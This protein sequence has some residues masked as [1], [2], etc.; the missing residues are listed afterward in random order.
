[1]L[2][3]CILHIIKVTYIYN[4]TNS[5]ERAEEENYLLKPNNK[6][7]RE[8]RE[9]VDLIE[10]ERRKERKKKKKEERKKEEKEDRDRDPILFFHFSLSL[11]RKRRKGGAC[12]SH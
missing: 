4:Y 12:I 1:M 2:C 9:E 6:K 8:K 7:R 11:H 10:E 5:R 3:V